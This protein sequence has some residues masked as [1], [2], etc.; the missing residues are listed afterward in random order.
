MR[1]NGMIRCGKPRCQR[2]G[3]PSCNY[4]Y[5]AALQRLE[6]MKRHAETDEIAKQEK[7]AAA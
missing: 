4:C 7:N 5:K 1:G 3:A 6:D 2:L